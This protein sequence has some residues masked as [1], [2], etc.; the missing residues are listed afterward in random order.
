M[1]KASSTFLGL[2]RKLTLNIQTIKYSKAL[3]Y[4]AYNRSKYKIA[5]RKYFNLSIS[6]CLCKS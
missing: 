5:V 1:N 4:Y 6:I 3:I 2:L